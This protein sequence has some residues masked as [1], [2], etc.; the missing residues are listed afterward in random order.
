MDFADLHRRLIGH[1]RERIRSGEWTERGLARLTGVSQP[2]MH[3]V[4]KGIR[5]LSSDT[6]D[7]L[8]RHLRIDLVDLMQEA[9]LEPAETPLVPMAAGHLGPDLPFP[10]LDG[11]RDRV[12]VWWPCPEKLLQPV[13][14]GLEAD[15]EMAAL[16]RAGDFA[17]L[18]CAEQKRLH[19]A[20]DAYYAVDL[21]SEGL[22]RRLEALPEGLG[23]APGPQRYVS[24]ADRNILEIVKAKVVWIGRNLEP[25][26]FVTRSPEETGREH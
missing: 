22:V 6:A 23:L 15:P 4:L 19:L 3:N 20:H 7:Q 16:Y 13:L 8:L 12:P 17:L 11:A 14:V 25:P 2:H 21:G 26:C 9:G 18:D 10:A 5:L 1:I 24:Y